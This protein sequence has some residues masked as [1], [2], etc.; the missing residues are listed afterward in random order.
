MSFY[1]LF[2]LAF[3]LLGCMSG[4]LSANTKHDFTIQGG[5]KYEYFVIFMWGADGRRSQYDYVQKAE[6]SN[7]FA[8]AIGRF[9]EW[10]SR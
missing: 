9:H 2:Q 4:N 5:W 6:F 7:V 3:F 8:G 1:P 10:S